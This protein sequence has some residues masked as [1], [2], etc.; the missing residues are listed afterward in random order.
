MRRLVF[1][2]L[3]SLLR[4]LPSSSSGGNKPVVYDGT[5]WYEI[6]PIDQVSTSQQ[7][8]PLPP[9]SNSWKDPNVEIYVSIVSFRDSERC[10]NTL[11]DLFAKAKYPDRIRVGLVQ[12]TAQDEKDCMDL[13]CG[14]KMWQ[15]MSTCTRAKQVSSILMAKF[16]S[17]G[18]SFARYLT[19]EDM[20]NAEFC[21]QTDS[22]VN[23]V[24]G[25]D[26]VALDTWAATKNEYAVLS[27]SLPD[28]MKT[29]SEAI[30]S[31]KVVPHLCS[32]SWTDRGMVRN[33]KAK[34]AAN[35]Q[36]PI[37][38]NLWSAGFSFSKCHAERK[39]PPDPHL[40]QCWDGE[41]FAKYARY[42]SIYIYIYIYKYISFMNIRT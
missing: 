30:T 26:V 20:G 41:E 6:A 24:R 7:Q 42:L 38:S 12:Q 17:K 25:W 22:H 33:D 19:Q 5:A 10:A 11:K 18:P 34:A 16:E 4:L 9:I 1:I 27:T 14:N 36:E 8:R 35:L 13:F 29:S 28:S 3:L 39:V 23:F 40:H 32:S 37:L 2:L 15:S 31:S 21:M